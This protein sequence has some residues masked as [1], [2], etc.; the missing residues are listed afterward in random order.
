MPA[1][2]KRALLFITFGS[3]IQ[4]VQQPG[5]DEAFEQ[6]VVII[7]DT[8]G[9]TE[10]GA[11][12]ATMRVCLAALLKKHD[13]LAL[14][15][16]IPQPEGR[17]KLIEAMLCGQVRG[18]ELCDQCPGST[19]GPVIVLTDGIDNHSEIRFK[20]ATKEP[21]AGPEA[22]AARL[23]RQ[24]GDRFGT[25]QGKPQ[26]EVADYVAHF[27]AETNTTV[28]MCVGEPASVG[29][30]ADAY[31]KAA[32]SRAQQPMVVSVQN[33]AHLDPI[34]I[35]SL[36]DTIVKTIGTKPKTVIV[37]P[38]NDRP[39]QMPPLGS[40][41]HQ[42]M[43]A[44]LAMVPQKDGDTLTLNRIP[45]IIGGL[46]GQTNRKCWNPVSPNLPPNLETVT[47][48]TRR[49]L[50]GV[51]PNTP[52]TISEIVKESK[53]LKGSG[54]L[55][56]TAQERSA[57]NSLFSSLALAYPMTISKVNQTHGARTGTNYIIKVTPL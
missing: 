53:K 18:K 32:T 38:N 40:E 30:L 2:G 19:I 26:S 1:A 5:P 57:L 41:A 46:A 33:G 52:F 8:S 44:Y 55:P 7:Y 37:G 11:T 54:I 31:L 45:F 6:L 9:S 3:D 56:I 16:A 34:G 49:I 22:V 42:K 43:A 29:P 12:A 51:P 25:L 39:L 21:V 20:T 4:L 47:K 17:T 28:I 27:A 48:V 13:L 23:D 10:S 36:V 14:T 15:T 35:E 50:Q 24:P